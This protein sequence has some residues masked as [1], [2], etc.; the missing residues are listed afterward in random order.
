[1]EDGR[2]QWTYVDVG[3]RSDAYAE[4]TSGVAPGDTVAVDGHYALAHD[5]PVRVQAANDFA[6][7]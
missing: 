5:A 4:I 7:E 3:A 2:A 6:V 1:V